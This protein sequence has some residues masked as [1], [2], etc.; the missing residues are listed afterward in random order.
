MEEL[1]HFLSRTL[2]EV[3]QIQELLD[4]AFE[5]ELIGLEALV[6]RLP[7]IEPAVSAGLMPSRMM[8]GQFDLKCKLCL[9]RTEQ[10][11]FGFTVKHIPLVLDILAREKLA[12]ELKLHISVKQTHLNK[13]PFSKS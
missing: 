11:Q 13:N 12:Q 6:Q 8:V 5:Q 7:E 1:H 2:S 3:V 10:Q 9:Q 4:Q